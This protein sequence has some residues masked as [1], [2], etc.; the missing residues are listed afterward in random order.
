LH[1]EE[2][3]SFYHNL[4]HC[5]IINDK[6]QNLKHINQPIS[7]MNHIHFYIDKNDKICKTEFFKIE[8][9]KENKNKYKIIL[10]LIKIYNNKER[11]ENIIKFLTINRILCTQLYYT[12]DFETE[13]YYK[14]RIISDN[15]RIDDELLKFIEQDSYMVKNNIFNFSYIHKDL[16]TIKKHNLLINK[17][18]NLLK[19]YPNEKLRTTIDRYRFAHLR[20]MSLDQLKKEYIKEKIKKGG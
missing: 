1:K 16:M 19:H 10:Y 13:M 8:K 5:I 11:Y 9:C 20:N 14:Y 2:I 3:F 18:N 4:I 7:V 17:F 6:Y 15:I 12:L